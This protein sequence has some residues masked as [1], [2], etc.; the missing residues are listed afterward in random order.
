MHTRTNIQNLLIFNQK[1]VSPV[2]LLLHHAARDGADGPAQ[3][4]ERPPAPL[5]AVGLR[6]RAHLRGS[7]GRGEVS[8]GGT[9]VGNSGSLSTHLRKP[10]GQKPHPTQPTWSRSRSSI[11]L[12]VSSWSRCARYTSVSCIALYRASTSAV[13]VCT[14]RLMMRV[15]NNESM[16]YLDSYKRL[17]LPGSRSSFFAAPASPKQRE[18]AR[19]H[20]RCRAAGQ[21]IC[22]QNQS[23]LMR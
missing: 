2:L 10:A 1:N 20:L 13:W 16:Q 11:W 6:P 14:V 7:A 12:S 22:T 17:G 15:E 9:G 19:H 8:R 23:T 5:P 18:H 4:V 3:P 21:R